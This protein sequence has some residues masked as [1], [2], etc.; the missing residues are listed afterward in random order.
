MA[1]SFC[2]PD[3]VVMQ[4]RRC[5]GRFADT[6]LVDGAVLPFDP[7]VGGAL[8]ESIVGTAHAGSPLQTQEDADSRMAS[9]R[10]RIFF[11]R[12]QQ[13]LTSWGAGTVFDHLT[14][15]MLGF[16]Q[17]SGHAVGWAGHSWTYIP[18]IAADTPVDDGTPGELLLEGHPLVFEPGMYFAILSVNNL[19]VAAGNLQDQGANWE[20]G[21]SSNGFDEVCTP[22]AGVTDGELIPFAFMQGYTP[23]NIY[24]STPVTSS[25]VS[26]SPVALQQ[27]GY[28]SRH[29]VT[30]GSL[31]CVR[32]Q[33]C[34]R[35]RVN[36]ANWPA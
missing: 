1:L 35:F 25:P 8:V 31:I 28:E 2:N 15:Q 27:A 12:L 34:L 29:P 14:W 13:N 6:V 33:A 4:R 16:Y 32:D 5:R 7:D 9:G 18:Q 20:P 10:Y 11:F 3:L 24:L 22:L 17:V 23:A 36:K 21:S 19:L 26:G 30:A